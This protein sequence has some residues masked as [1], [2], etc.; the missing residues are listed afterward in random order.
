MCSSPSGPYY[1]SLRS[2]YIRA[3]PSRT[4]FNFS[5]FDLQATKNGDFS[6]ARKIWRLSAMVMG[7]RVSVTGRVL[8]NNVTRLL[9]VKVFR[10]EAFQEFDAATAHH[11]RTP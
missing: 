7:E 6:S 9:Q 3:V 4:M 8:G 1:V 11:I 2:R 10:F 5:Q